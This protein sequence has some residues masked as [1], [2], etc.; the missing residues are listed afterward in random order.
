MQTVIKALSLSESTR[1]MSE[2]GQRRG[3]GLCRGRSYTD[4]RSQEVYVAS[5]GPSSAAILLTDTFCF[6][7]QFSLIV[8]LLND[9]THLHPLA[10]CPMT[11]FTLGCRLR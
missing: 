8:C 5:G 3:R 10:T 11:S 4:L 7:S 1:E 2:D 6:L 9:G